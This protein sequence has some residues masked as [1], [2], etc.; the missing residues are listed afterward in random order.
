METIDERER[1]Q[2]KDRK[3]QSCSESVRAGWFCCVFKLSFVQSICEA[4][5]V[6]KSSLELALSIILKE[7]Q[8]HE[9]IIR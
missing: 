1:Q 3:K 7:R 8:L 5:L 4:S 9:S 6:F 2:N